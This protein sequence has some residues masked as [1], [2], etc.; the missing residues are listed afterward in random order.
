MTCDIPSR[1]DLCHYGDF[2][3]N[4]LDA[5]G[6]KNLDF[7]IYNNLVIHFTLV[8]NQAILGLAALAAKIG[9]IERGLSKASAG[10]H[11]TVCQRASLLRVF[12]RRPLASGI[13]VSEL[14]G[15]EG[16]DDGARHDVL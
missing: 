3:Y 12:D 5:P 1:Q 11:G 14:L 7:G 10:V 16:L 2:G 13:R 9:A 15:H 6:Q 4:V 8:T